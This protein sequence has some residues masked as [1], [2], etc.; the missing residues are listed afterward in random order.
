MT[1]CCT[2]SNLGTPKTRIVNV[3]DWCDRLKTCTVLEG[4]TCAKLI[5]IKLDSND[6]RKVAVEHCL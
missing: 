5:R 6:S 2:L 3:E 1:E 4:T